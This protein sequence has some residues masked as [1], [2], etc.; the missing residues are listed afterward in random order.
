MEDP[1]GVSGA[2]RAAR[3]GA[4]LAAAVLLAVWGGPGVGDDAA[5]LARALGSLGPP[6]FLWGRLAVEEESPDGA[7]TP[8]GGV[9]V[10]VYPYLPGVLAELERVR[11]SARESGSQ[12]ETAV[13]RVQELLRAYRREVE[14]A[15]PAGAAASGGLVRRQASDT[16]GVF[17]FD[18][19]PSGEWLL[20]ATRVTPY[21]APASGRESRGRASGRESRFL[22]PPGRGPAREAEV[23]VA[24]VRVVPGERS[25]VLLTDRARWL[26]GPLR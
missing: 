26:V 23:W 8:L 17:V 5:D 21:A 6:G 1:P 12:F 22:T 20:V 13:A 24:R 18:E 25:R 3:A 7:W 9:E 10:T 14:A 16:T 4:A 2:R 19:L 11:R 15:G